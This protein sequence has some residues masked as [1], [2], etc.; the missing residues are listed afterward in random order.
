[1]KEDGVRRP[2]VD[3]AFAQQESATNAAGDAVKPT[4]YGRVDE[5]GTGD[6]HGWDLQRCRRSLPE[7]I[8]WING[9]MDGFSLISFLA[10]RNPFQV[11]LSATRR[12]TAFCGRH[13]GL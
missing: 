8:G 9:E 13:P 12:V 6:C 5:L 4:S 11:Y 3:R 7:L 10:F 1:M 2:A